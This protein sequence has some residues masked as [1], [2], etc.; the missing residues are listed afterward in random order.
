MQH[1]ATR[2]DHFELG[3]GSEQICHIHG[4]TNHLLEVVQYEQ[5]L[6]LTQERFQLVE[7]WLLPHFFEVEC[8]GNGRYDQGGIRDGSQ[9]HE[10]HS[11]MEAIAYFSSYLQAQAG[12]SRAANTGQSGQSPPFSRQPATAV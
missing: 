9:V 7:R 10:V 2:H 6:P 5:Q 1:Y 11:L 8:L 4:S 3:A 12:V